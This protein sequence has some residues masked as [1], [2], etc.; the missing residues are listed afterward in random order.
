MV[1]EAT[2]R[3]VVPIPRKDIG[4]NLLVSPSFYEF[5]NGESDWTDRSALF[6]VC[7]TQTTCF[8]VYLRPNVYA[9]QPVWPTDLPRELKFCWPTRSGLN[10]DGSG[11]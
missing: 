6:A 7:Q 5:D 8:G 11:R 9:F 2:E 10:H 4:A 1:R 3:I